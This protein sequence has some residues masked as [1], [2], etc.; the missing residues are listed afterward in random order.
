MAKAVQ[1][2]CARIQ[3]RHDAGAI[4]AG[5]LPSRRAKMPPSAPLSAAQIST[6][7]SMPWASGAPA[8]VPK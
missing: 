4:A 7:H 2:G 8:K 5:P 3:A 1:M 6:H